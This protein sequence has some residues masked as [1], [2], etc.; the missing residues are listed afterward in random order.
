MFPLAAAP[1]LHGALTEEGSLQLRESDVMGINDF[2]L[3]MRLSI[4]L[5]DLFFFFCTQK[6]KKNSVQHLRAKNDM[7]AGS[8]PNIIVKHCPRVI[9]V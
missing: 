8:G 7:K 1:L 3:E 6:E 4:F 9:T 2:L 5:R